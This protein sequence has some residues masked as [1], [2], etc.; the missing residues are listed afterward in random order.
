M[1]CG[2]A[3]PEQIAACI[4]IA[5]RWFDVLIDLAGLGSLALVSLL[6]WLFQRLRRDLGTWEAEA[7]REK[8][9]R[10]HADN[11]ALEARHRA[12]LAESVAQQAK[13]DRDDLED[14]LKGGAN[15][16]QTQLA[17]TQLQLS[18]ACARIDSALTITAGGTG[19]FWSRPIGRRCEDYTLRMARSIP[20]LIFGNQKGGVGKSTLVTNLAAAFA[21]KGER[22][23]TV[24]LDYQGSHSS[25]T[26]MERGAS[27][28]EPESLI[29]Y[30]FQDELHVDWKKLAIRRVTENLHVIPAFYNF[31]LIERHVEYQWALNTTRDDVRYRLARALLSDEVQAEATGFDRVLIDA[32]PRFTLGFVNGICAATHLYVPTVVDAMSTSAVSAFARQFAELQPVVNPRLRWAGIIGTMTSLKPQDPLALPKIAEDAA[33]QAERAAQHRLQTHEPLFIRKPVIRRDPYLARGTES[34]IAYLHESK[35]CLMFDELVSVIEAK[36]PSRKTRL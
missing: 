23:L 28:E 10:I 31:E 1:D 5:K 17:E 33:D 30:L 26:Q 29:D 34:G 7:A 22:V 18:A 24:D 12:E 19:K 20:I 27:N 25:L 11:T 13:Q 3:S 35:V 21:K 2:W 4:H 32:P 36:A 15:E 9:L 8:E 14:I 16:L 6:I